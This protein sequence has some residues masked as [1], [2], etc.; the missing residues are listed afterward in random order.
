MTALGQL[1]PPP[2]AP[3][4]LLLLSLPLLLPLLC[5]PCHCCLLPPPPNRTLSADVPSDS[6][7]ISVCRTRG[8]DLINDPVYNKV[9]THKA[10]PRQHQSQRVAEPPA[11]LPL[12][13]PAFA[14]GCLPA[15]LPCVAFS[16]DQRRMPPCLSA[17]GW[18][19]PRY[20][21]A[22][23]LLGCAGGPPSP[24]V[25]QMPLAPPPPFPF[26][27]LRKGT[28]HPCFLSLA[29]SCAGHRAPHSGAGAPGPE[30]AAAPSGDG[31]GGTE[32]PHAR[33]LLVCGRCAVLCCAVLCCAGGWVCGE[34]W[35]GLLLLGVGGWV[36]SAREWQ[37]HAGCW[38]GRAGG[39]VWWGRLECLAGLVGGGGGGRSRVLYSL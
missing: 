13:L 14:P 10:G 17:G 35:V 11:C 37:R 3:P 23:P 39:R 15:C 7:D 31:P 33:C 34:L 21:G 26:S 28:Q 30:G 32:V 6:L 18:P 4:L 1:S 20:D 5:C 27:L 38:W 8:R 12:A 9:S 36:P 2:R 24:L 16:P 29:L 22:R 25:L 19:L